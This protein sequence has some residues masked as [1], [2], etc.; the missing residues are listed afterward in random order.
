MSKHRLASGICDLP[1][2]FSCLLCLLL[3]MTLF[4]NSLLEIVQAP[5]AG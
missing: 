2:A 4:S 1:L 5:A 3:G